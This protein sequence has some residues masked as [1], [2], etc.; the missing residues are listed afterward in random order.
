MARIAA[1]DGVTRICATPHI[2]HDHDVRIHEVPERVWDVNAALERAG[3][4][5]GSCPAARW[6]RPRWPDSTTRS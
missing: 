5:S 2:R 6:P 4:A 3:V 1:G